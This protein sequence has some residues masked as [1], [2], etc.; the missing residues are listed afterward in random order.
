MTEWRV[1]DHF[2]D[3]DQDDVKEETYEGVSVISTKHFRAF[4]TT[5]QDHITHAANYASD[6]IAAQE[7]INPESPLSVASK[8]AQD[9]LTSQ[10]KHSHPPC[11]NPAAKTMR[12]RSRLAKLTSLQF[13]LPP[14]QTWGGEIR[15]TAL[16]LQKALQV[17]AEYIFTQ[18]PLGQAWKDNAAPKAIA[19]KSSCR[20][21]KSPE[22]APQEK[23]PQG[24][25][26]HSIVGFQMY[27]RD[28]K[29]SVS[30]HQ[31]EAV[32]GLWSWSLKRSELLDPTAEEHLIRSKMVVVEKSKREDIEAALYLW[33]TQTRQVREYGA[34]EGIERPDNLSIPTSILL[35]R[36][37]S[38]RQ[39]SGASE[40]RETNTTNADGFT[41]L[42][43]ATSG[44]TSLLQLMAQDVYTVFINRIVDIVGDLRGTGDP[45]DYLTMRDHSLSTASRATPV[46]E[47]TNP[48]IDALANALVSAGVA[49]RE[50]ALMSIVPAFLYQAKLPL[51]DEDTV[52]SLLDW[53]KSLRR[54]LKFREG[55]ALITWMLPRCPARFHKQG[56][57]CLGDL[58]RRAAM[59][60][61]RRDQEFGL[62][63][64]R[65]L[66]KRH[67]ALASDH[68]IQ[69]ILSCYE[70]LHDFLHDRTTSKALFMSSEARKSEVERRTEFERQRIHKN[71][72]TGFGQDDLEAVLFFITTHLYEHELILSSLLS[73]LSMAI[74]G[75]HPE[76]IEDL[77]TRI[78]LADLTGIPNKTPEGKGI[79]ESSPLLTALNKKRELETIHSLLD[80]PGL[81][82]D[83][84]DFEC[85]LGD[86]SRTPLVCAIE[87][88]R[89]DVVCS[90]LRRGANLQVS[91]G[92]DM[93]PLRCAFRKGNEGMIRLLIDKGAVLG[94]GDGQAALILAA[95]ANS[96]AVIQW[97]LEE[98]A[99]IREK[100]VEGRTALHFAA[101]AN[102]EG[103]VRLLV[104]NGAEM[105]E[106]DVTGF[107]P[108]H[109]ATEA[110]NNV[111]IQ[112]LLE[113]GAKV[114]EKDIDGCT[115]LHLAA[116]WGGE[117]AIRLLLKKG[118]DVYAEDRE[119]RTA[120]HVAARKG[121]QNILRLLLEKSAEI[122]SVGDN[123]WSSL[124]SVNPEFGRDPTAR[125]LEEKGIEKPLGDERKRG[126]E[127]GEEVEEEGEE[128]GR[129]WGEGEEEE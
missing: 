105:H 112:F 88:N 101:K 21:S 24:T 39:S 109:F 60:K 30:S 99:D 83:G 9:A 62:S 14:E 113:K 68:Q 124:W 61:K 104:E 89:A 122:G 123:N 67:S 90:I 110:K 53:S 92:N 79:F 72:P 45:E 7:A 29:W 51:L 81:D 69:G 27:N 4:Y 57:R 40:S 58:Y 35:S 97:L 15:T 56:L 64:M 36:A 84:T 119:G 49:T 1:S 23:D 32:L 96:E 70:H 94:E 126:E 74:D 91:K 2:P 3:E 80:W 116:T 22:H 121:H 76:L 10:S 95:E 13:G 63:G 108:L 65:N 93:R 31:F 73:T 12:S 66:K 75:N 128:E 106:K 52:Q 19:W 16:Q 103:V 115:P 117:E 5:D 11:I 59:S 8:E 6:W 100:D 43:I 98:G 44:S 50:E 42:G 107:T 125:L 20:F 28:G 47:L 129:G 17:S 26:D 25:E 102:S 82:V 114:H 55:A 41:I 85:D 48:H 18:F 37:Q 78:R 127:E 71:S 120:L 86:R 118:A 46:F 54:D 111:V 33:V 77:W 34:V 38:S 87:A